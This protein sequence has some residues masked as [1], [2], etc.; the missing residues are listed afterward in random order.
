MSKDINK[1]HVRAMLAMQHLYLLAAD[2]FLASAMR[3]IE[4]QGYNF[5]RE[6]KYKMNQMLRNA[7][8]LEHQYAEVFNFLYGVKEDPRQADTMRRDANFLARVGCKAMDRI[9]YASGYYKNIKGGDCMPKLRYRI[10][11]YEKCLRCGKRLHKRKSVRSGLTEI[12]AKRYLNR[13]KNAN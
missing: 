10:Y 2:R 8:A 4:R 11:E 1:D 9:Y 6:Q 3:D 5:K 12:A 13:L 7:K